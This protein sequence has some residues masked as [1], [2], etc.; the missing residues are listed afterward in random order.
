MS[1]FI[2]MLSQTEE[3]YLKAIY[4][5]SLNSEKSVSTN[6]IAEKLQTNASSVTDM[7]QK[8][9]DKKLVNYTKYQGS[10]LTENGEHTALKII[11]K[12]RL[13]E[14]FLVER[15][16]FNWDEVHEVAEQLEH[17]NSAKLVEELNIYLGSPEYDP[18]GDPIPDA[19]GNL[20]KSPKKKLSQ[21][22]KG[23]RATCKGFNDSSSPFLQFL[24][25]QEIGLNTQIE[26]VHIESFDESMTVLIAGKEI[27]L[28][29]IATDNI[30][31]E[32]IKV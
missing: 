16:N 31:I 17:I 30:Y 23:N 27:P 3:N 22:K 18:H 19:K 29:K 26:V 28:S 25:K 24:A 7:V 10:L 21:L 6:K 5:L 1:K 11:R 15:L 32:S 9:S 12:H 2:L 20:P 14:Y 4:S 8:L 13:W